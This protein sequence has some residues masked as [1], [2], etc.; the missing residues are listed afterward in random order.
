MIYYELVPF[1]PKH[2]EIL[3]P[4]SH[5][6]Y[7]LTLPWVQLALARWPVVMTF[8]EGETP[9]AILGLWPKRSGMLLWILLDESFRQHPLRLVRWARQTLEGWLNQ[10]MTSAF[11]ADCDP[12][13]HSAMRFLSCLGFQLVTKK[14]TSWRFEKWD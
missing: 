6:R 8:L 1:Q 12:T 7:A 3:V 9:C 10:G 2:L 13:D 4:R 14:P 11:L 5:E